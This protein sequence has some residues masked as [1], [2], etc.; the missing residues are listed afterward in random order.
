MEVKKAVDTQKSGG[1]SRLI[2][3]STTV[4]QSRFNCFFMRYSER[5]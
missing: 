2:F 4:G 5:M 1:F 3:V